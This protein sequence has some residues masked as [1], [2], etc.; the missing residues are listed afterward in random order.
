MNI[1]FLLNWH[2]NP[3]HIPILVAKQL[4][5]Y[6]E[7]DINLILL[8]PLSPSEVTIAIGKNHIP[9]GL[10]AMVHCFAARSRNYPI[11]SI[12]TLLDEPPT[13]LISL[14]ENNIKKI[15][16]IKN[17][18]IGYIGEFGKI[19]IDNIAQNAKIDKN[20]YETVRVGMEA[21]HALLSHQVD[22]A[23]GLSCFQLLEVKEKCSKVDF[24]RIDLLANLG[25]CCFCS[26]MFIAHETFIKKEP[27]LIKNFMQATYR[28]MLFTRE[29]PELAFEIFLQQ[30]PKLDSTLYQKIFFHTLPFFSRELKNIERDWEKVSKYSKKLEIIDKNYDHNMCFTSQ[31]SPDLSLLNTTEPSS[32]KINRSEKCLQI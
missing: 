30:K 16:D 27:N 12:G 24:L 6:K 8:E 22:A 31:F 1:P 4:G 32:L 18:R 2:L 3:Y 14:G 26:I 7:I 15:S 21:A 29:Q 19:M 17:K 13:G 20:K 11:Q 28:G 9:I 5:M 10:K 25:C 23:I